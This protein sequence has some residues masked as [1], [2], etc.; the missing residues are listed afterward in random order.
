VTE[1][2]TVA[3]PLEAISHAAFDELYRSS[4]SDVYAYVASLVRDPAVAEEITAVAFERAFR[5]RRL[6]RPRRG[7]PRQWLFGIARNA[8]LDELRRTRRQSPALPDSTEEAGEEV[9]HVVERSLRRSAVAGAIRSLE[10]AD[11]ELVA[12]KFFAGLSNREIARVLRI[13][14]SNAGTRVHR[15]LVHLREQCRVT[16]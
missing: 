8:A 6:Y 7:T 3:L 9:E 11:R 15:V 16:P 1:T 4:A 10:P 13:S 12:L 2:L 14:E 5:R